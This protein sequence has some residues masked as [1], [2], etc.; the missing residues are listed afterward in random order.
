MKKWLFCNQY[1]STR[2]KSSRKDEHKQ[3]DDEENR[4]SEDVFVIVDIVNLFCLSFGS[5]KMFVLQI[6]EFSSSWIYR[7]LLLLLFL[8]NIL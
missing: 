7:T 1:L 4:L 8:E 3:E 2:I 5:V 6:A